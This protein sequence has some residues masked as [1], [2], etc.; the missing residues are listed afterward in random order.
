MMTGEI[1][2]PRI[3]GPIV[4]ANSWKTGS[5]PKRAART[6]STGQ[7]NGKRSTKRTNGT[8]IRARFCANDP[9]FSL[10]VAPP[11]KVLL[12]LQQVQRTN[13]HSVARNQ[14]EIQKVGELTTKARRA[15]RKVE[16]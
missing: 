16:N 6:V 8:P 10:L 12:P 2:N 13:R 7:K 14:T 15:R 1:G 9:T 4:A 3:S 11:R 5:R